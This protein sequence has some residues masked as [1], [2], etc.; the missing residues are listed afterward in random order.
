[1]NF[2]NPPVSARQPLR[3][4]IADDEAPA[5]SRIS[6]LL[7]DIAADQPTVLLA[8][9]GNGEEALRALQ[10][11][12]A[13]LILADIRMPVMDGMAL[14]ARVR[15][16]HPE[17]Q[18][19]FTTAYDEYA[20]SAFDLAATDYLVKPVRAIRL[21]DALERVRTRLPQSAAAHE[22]LDG[23]ARKQVCVNE[24]GRVIFLPIADIVYLKAELKYVTART[25]ERSYLLDESLVQLEEEF[26][27]LFLRIHRNCLV[28][29]RFVRGV[30]RAQADASEG[31]SEPMWQVI[32]DGVQERLT[33]S[34]RQW[35]TVKTALGM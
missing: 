28:A 14:A 6:A 19:I 5:R 18:I 24:R 22:S 20:L 1:M 12:P 29:R 17:T 34:R 16:E 23:K 27:D 33:I 30:E 2:P 13:D 15:A 8:M 21:A 4:I 10:N 11:T 9:V 26:S 31:H 25:T 32:V 7:S 35:P 3:V